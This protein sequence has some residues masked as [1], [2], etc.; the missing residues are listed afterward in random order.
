MV[1]ARSSRQ[2]WVYSVDRVGGGTENI[3]V[4]WYIHIVVCV[5]RRH[6]AYLSWINGI[7]VDSYVSGTLGRKLVLSRSGGTLWLEGP[8]RLKWGVIIK[9][10]YKG[11][12]YFLI[13]P[14]VLV[15]S[16]NGSVGLSAIQIGNSV[17]ICGVFDDVGG[18][19]WSSVGASISVWYCR[20]GKETRTAGLYTFRNVR[21]LYLVMT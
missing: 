18:H 6:T 10:V 19:S 1:V 13:D 16:D 8:L 3:V 2:R 14:I 11:R 7:G 4:L 21:V 12:I 17:R 5:Y 9:T 20:W 15:E